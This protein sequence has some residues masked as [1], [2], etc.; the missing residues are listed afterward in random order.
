MLKQAGLGA[1]DLWATGAAFGDYDNDGFADLF[2][3]HYVEFHL[4]DM[5]AAQ[6]I[7]AST[8]ASM[9]SAAL[10]E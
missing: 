9:C 5:A 6:W 10:S 4:N 3:S 8:W 1:D 7:H 2:V